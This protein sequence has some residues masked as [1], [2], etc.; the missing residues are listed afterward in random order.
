MNNLDFFIIRKKNMEVVKEIHLVLIGL[1]V[2]VFSPVS[3]SGIEIAHV[4]LEK[5]SHRKR[6][7]SSSKP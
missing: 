4:R 2:S 6:H 1:T 5:R 7:R 3:N